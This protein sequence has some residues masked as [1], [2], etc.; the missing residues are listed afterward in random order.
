VNK[1]A[2]KLSCE[3]HIWK[4]ILVAAAGP[5]PP[6]PPTAAYSLPRL[7]ALAVE[8]M[9]VR[10]LCTDDNFLRAQP[11]L[12][13]TR[14]APAQRDVQELFLVPGGQYMLASHCARG[15][16]HWALSLYVTDHKWGPAVPIATI[17]TEQKAYHIRAVYAQHNGEEGLLISYQRRFFL[18]G[19]GPET[20][21]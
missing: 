1:R 18:H 20:S 16:E 2:Y 11:R 9:V 5:L 14:V 6:I 4:A 3:A 13:R 12:H 8:R 17:Y 15:G 21:K 7:S 19:G 10:A